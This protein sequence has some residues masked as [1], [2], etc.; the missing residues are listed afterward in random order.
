LYRL[1]HPASRLSPQ[2][3]AQLGRWIDLE[4]GSAVASSEGR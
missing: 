2:D 1:I 3:R 4:L